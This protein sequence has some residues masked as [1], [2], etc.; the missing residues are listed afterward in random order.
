MHDGH[1]DGRWRGMEME[2]IKYLVYTIMQY[3]FPD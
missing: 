1:Q 2:F 3:H